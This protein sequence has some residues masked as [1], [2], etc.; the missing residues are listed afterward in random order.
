MRGRNRS[1][2]V[3]PFEEISQLRGLLRSCTR[4]TCANATFARRTEFDERKF[5]VFLISPVVRVGIV[6]S[7][8]VFDIMR[9][10]A[11]QGLSDD[12]IAGPGN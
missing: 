7:G 5:V 12:L 10:T 11:I 4:V 3:L 1:I 8:Y 6:D 2:K 9:C